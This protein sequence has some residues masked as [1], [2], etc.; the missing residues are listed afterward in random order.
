LLALADFDQRR[1]W[2]ELGHASLFSFLHRELGLS[3]GAA[4]HRKIAAELV[5]RFPAVVE[6]LR[7]GRLCITSVIELAKVLEPPAAATSCRASST[8]PSGRRRRSSPSCG[9]C[10]H[11]AAGRGDHPS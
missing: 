11:P 2:V 8:G 4:Y 10:S 1:L 3:T 9:R 7:D 5:H 6:P